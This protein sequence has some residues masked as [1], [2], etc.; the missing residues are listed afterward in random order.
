LSAADD[1]VAELRAGRPV[2][3]PFDTV[4]GL[5]GDPRR[6]EV[7]R[8]IYELKRRPPMLAAA[9]VAAEVDRLLELVP[10]LRGRA[11]VL[12]RTL[13]P[14]PYTLVLAN[15][16]RRFRWLTGAHAETIGVRVPALAGPTAEVL[17]RVG[18]VVATSANRHGE[19]DPATLDAV[20]GAIKAACLAVDGGPLPGTA[21]TVLD[22]TGDEPRVL[23]EGPGAG[24]ALRRLETAVRSS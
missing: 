13:L 12:A 7:T 16:A 22:L 23:R 11:E 3:L 10:E 21:S 20:P 1:A 19:L 24:E 2:V 6:P 9:L 5:A 14:G 17:A 18:A 4:Y 8:R 15:P